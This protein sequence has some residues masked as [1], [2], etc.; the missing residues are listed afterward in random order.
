MAPPL[1]VVTGASRGIGRATAAAFARDG[2]RIVVAARSLGRLRECAGEIERAGSRAIAVEADVSRDEGAR[3]LAEAVA[4]EGGALDVLVNNAGL[5]RVAPFLDTKIRE[6]WDELLAA[7]LTGTF[8]PTLRLAPALLRA[9]RP[10][11][12]NVL[13]VAALRGFPWN[14]GYAASKWG[15][16]GLTE[17][18]RAEFGDRLR[19]TAVFPGA[20]DTDLWEGAPFPHDRSK[21]LRPGAVAQAIVDAW[22]AEAPPAEIVLETPPGSVGA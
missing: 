1:V 6:E 10:H 3:A 21:M 12:F 20:T 11:L 22:R 8:L 18:L 13:S 14:A 4:R 2:A 15:A 5:F 9:P 17:V 16:R 19:V 7:N